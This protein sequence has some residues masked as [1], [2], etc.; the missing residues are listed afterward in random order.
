MKL[1]IVL[2]LVFAAVISLGFWT[3]HLLI[4]QAHDLIED[5]R[6]VE[7]E[8]ENN[9]WDTAYARAIGLEKVW[10]KEAEWWTTILDH[11]E[12]DE[13]KFTLART[14]EYIA[15]KDPVLANGQL[16]ELRLMIENI[17]DKEALK[18]K[19]IL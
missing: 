9:R 3:N 19:N 4:V 8:I 17:P 2:L 5:V 11:C 12:I 13:I 16:E 10:D 14:K 15:G 6:Q 18:I 7:L 1:L